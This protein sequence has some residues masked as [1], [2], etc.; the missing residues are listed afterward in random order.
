LPGHDRA[1][2]TAVIGTLGAGFPGELESTANTTPDAFCCTGDGGYLLRRTVWQW[3]FVHGIAKGAR[4]PCDRSP[5]SHLDYTQH[6][7]R[8]AKALFPFGSNMLLNLMSTALNYRNRTKVVGYGFTEPAFRGGIL[9]DLGGTWPK[10]PG[11]AR[12]G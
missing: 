9:K 2:K 12:K 10:S 6:G 4:G 3:D 8:S 5:I 11:Q 1:S 7:M